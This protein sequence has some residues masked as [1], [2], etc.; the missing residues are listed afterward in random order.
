MEGPSVLLCGRHSVVLER[1]LTLHSDM[2]MVFEVLGCN[3]LKPIIQSSYRGI[4]TYALKRVSRQILLGLDYL[5]TDCGI[6]HT[7]IKPENIL[8]CVSEAEV[9]R[10]VAEGA[11][12]RSAG[13][14]GR[15]RK[16][17]VGGVQ[18]SQSAHAAILLL[19]QSVQLR[20][21]LHKR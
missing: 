7:D 19:P 13:E 17:G 2:V 10:L 14:R 9:K 4:P 1:P 5:H 11:T 18:T 8:L 3:L 6:I 12:K 20:R 15:G 16:G 21:V